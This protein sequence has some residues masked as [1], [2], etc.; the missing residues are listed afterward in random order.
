MNE[1]PLS[2][3]YILLAVQLFSAAWVLIR[4]MEPAPMDILFSLISAVFGFV[5]AQ[6]ILNGNV[7]TTVANVTTTEYVAYQSLPVHYLLLSLAVFMT[8]ITVYVAVMVVKEVFS[9]KNTSIM[10]N[11]MEEVS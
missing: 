9:Q 3:F 10:K 7:V 2:M 1:I 5:N 6:S 4:I 11:W 8:I